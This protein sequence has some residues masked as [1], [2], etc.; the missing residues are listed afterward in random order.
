[1]EVLIPRNTTIPTREFTKTFYTSEKDQTKIEI[2][3]IEGE[4]TA[5]DKCRTIAK[6]CIVNIPKGKAGKEKFEVKF[7]IDKN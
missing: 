6:T 5:A 2:E 3:V 7:S 4:T 1:M